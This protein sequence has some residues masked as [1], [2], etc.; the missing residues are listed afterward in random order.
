MFIILVTAMLLTGCFK[1][2]GQVR[3]ISDVQNAII[4]IDGDKKGMTGDGYTTII[5]EEGEHKVR[6]YKER[7]EEWYY[8]GVK[9]V[10]VGAKSSV[11]INISTSSKPTGF[12][13]ARL[14]RE[15]K[16]EEERLAREKKAEKER[17]ARE[18]KA[19]EERLA[20]EKKE[21]ILRGKKFGL[22][23]YPKD[24]FYDTDTKRMWQ[25]DE[26]NGNTSLEKDWSSANSYCK[27]LSIGEYSDWRLATKNELINLYKHKSNLQNIGSDNYWS[28]T[29]YE[30]NNDSV[31]ILHFGNGSVNDDY[32]FMHEYVRCV[33]LDKKVEAEEKKAEE[34]KRVE[35]KKIAEEK[36]RV[37]E[38]KR[39]EEKKKAKKIAKLS[40]F[41]KR[42]K[43]MWVDDKASKGVKR[44]WSGA[45]KY[46]KNLKLLG[47]KNWRLATTNELTSLYKHKSNLKHTGSYFYWSSNTDSVG[48]YAKIVYFSNNG[49][50]GKN[51]MSNNCYVKCVRNRQ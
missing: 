50:V 38:K 4:Y 49:D 6:V 30:N 22:S 21:S 19:E 24:T 42:T 32:K 15:K 25:D 27:N 29:T 43:L 17:L 48:R 47:F 18:K 51:F 9:N 28:S 33:R 20:R 34:K 46:C 11:K 23:S 35:E 44:T 40:Y 39:L 26:N 41:D 14:A 3:I 37:E 45:K 16:A 8:E 13:L 7:G 2:E 36:K 1:E 12:R 5:L 31:W 10:F